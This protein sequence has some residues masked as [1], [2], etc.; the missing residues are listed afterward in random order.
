M[1]SIQKTP[2]L[3]QHCPTEF[4]SRKEAVKRQDMNALAKYR[5]Y[6][7]THPR[8]TY[9]FVELTD[10]C[11][12]RCIHCG[13]SCGGRSGANIDTEVLL[14]SLETV[15]QDFP[16]DSVM[17]CLTGGEPMLHPEF[18]HIIARIHK[19]GFPWGM[20]TNGTLIS[21]TAA[22]M[23]KNYGLGSISVSI[24]GT[25]STHNF[26]RRS[27]NAW[28]KA[29]NAVKL[30]IDEGIPVQVTSVI[31][32][33]NYTELNSLYSFMCDLHVASWRVINIEPIGR[34]LEYPDLLLNKEEFDGLL[35]FIR[36]KRYSHDTPMD[37]CF[38]CSHYLS[39]DFERETRDYYFLCGSGIYVG[40]ILCNGDISSCL[41]IER[42]PE[43]VQGNIRTDR[44]SDI[45]YNRFQLFRQDRSL[46]SAECLQCS[47]RAYCHGDAAHTWNYE[48]NKPM[49]CKMR[50]ES[51]YAL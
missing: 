2:G 17:I 10:S 39:F 27:S 15:A 29:V 30:L 21:R 46:T 47:E 8:L 40:S 24:D 48:S 32:K 23:L 50:K 38:G 41:D 43:F 51:Y 49:F 19:L 18:E 28:E 45:W 26:L 37:V 33:K 9:L 22:R 16:K 5:E 14:A 25:N 20:T 34:A 6:L 42:R 35:H 7:L 36:E 1:R 31:H 3:K 4:L 12:L 44:F 13:S 11:N